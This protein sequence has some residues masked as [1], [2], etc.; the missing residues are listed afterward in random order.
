LVSNQ[1]TRF[2]NEA[3]EI[4]TTHFLFQHTRSTIY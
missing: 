1:G 4:L 3:I 2:I